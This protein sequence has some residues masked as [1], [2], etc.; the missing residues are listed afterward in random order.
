MA[1]ISYTFSFTLLK[2]IFTLLRYRLPPVV[3]SQK[4]KWLEKAWSASIIGEHAHVPQLDRLVFRIGYQISA[5]TA[6]IDV[7]DSTSMAG[8]YS[9]WTQ[10]AFV[11]HS[12]IPC[13]NADRKTSL[14]TPRAYIG[15][16]CLVRMISIALIRFLIL[17]KK[18][19]LS[20]SSILP[21]TTRHHRRYRRHYCRRKQSRLFPFREH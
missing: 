11:H 4:R 21:C 19:S 7:S 8:E 5:V 16:K 20:K 3:P 14:K 13:L 1:P 2:R 6:W 12:S 10:I 17:K 9:N 15:S 18:K